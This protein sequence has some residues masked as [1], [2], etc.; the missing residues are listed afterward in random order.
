MV[1]EVL[2]W[3]NSSSKNCSRDG[4]DALPDRCAVIGPSHH[5]AC[6]SLVLG[7]S[8]VG[9]GV[10]KTQW[11]STVYSAVDG[12]F[13]IALRDLYLH[14][15]SRGIFVLRVCP[16][17]ADGCRVDP[18]CVATGRARLPLREQTACIWTRSPA[19][20]AS[21]ILQVPYSHT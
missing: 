13:P 1:D 12:H 3:V 17:E 8:S 7:G 15:Q 18:C 2:R 16:L 20:E 6:G 5:F 9:G 10:L 21:A 4:Q 19:N 14:L 11:I